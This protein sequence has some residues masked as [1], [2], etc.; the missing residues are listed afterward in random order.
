MSHLPP[1]LLAHTPCSTVYKTSHPCFSTQDPQEVRPKK[2]LLRGISTSTPQDEIRDFLSEKGFHPIKIA[3]LK[4]HITK[5]PMPLFIVSLRPT[6]N[7]EDIRKITN[8]NYLRISVEDFNSPTVKQCHNCQRYGLSSLKCTLA[9][10]CVRCAGAHICQLSRTGAV[11]TCANCRQTH[12]ASYR[13][14]P[15]NPENIR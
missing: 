8:F 15:S 2:F 11:A 14:C 7:V 4:N 1:F 13:G 3:Y 9:P 12:P 5:A 6:L 10:R